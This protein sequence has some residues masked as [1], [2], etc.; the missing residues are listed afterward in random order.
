LI[1]YWKIYLL[2]WKEFLLYTT[3][4]SGLALLIYAQNGW[5]GLFYIFW[6][7]VIGFLAVC[8]AY[9]H[10]KSNQLIF[11]HNLGLTTTTLLV[12]CVLSDIA[13]LGMLIGLFDLV[14]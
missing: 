7:K 10:A 9:R 4:F 12:I 1:R 6:T 11:F 2:I 8:L 3:I 5:M 13:V 14:A